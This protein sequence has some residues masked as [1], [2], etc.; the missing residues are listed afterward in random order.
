MY[1]NLLLL[2]LA[3]VAF[4]PLSAQEFSAGFRAGLNFAT[5]KGP[6]EMDDSGN[7]LEEYT[8]KSGFHVGGMA[9]LKFNDAF[10][11][12]GE[13]L[14]SQKGTESKYLGQS[15][16]IF[17][18]A[19]DIPVYATGDRNT[20]LSITNSYIDIPITAVGRLGRLEL[21]GGFN[22]GILVSSRGA[23]ELTFSGT[24][25]GGAPVDPFTIALEF[26]YF[27]DTFQRTDLNDVEIREIDGKDVLIPKTLTS[28]NQIVEGN[29]KL[30]NTLDFGLIGGLAFYL[31][32]GLFLG[33]RVNYGLSDLTKTNR[34]I[35]RK[36]LDSSK[37]FISREDDDR[38]L[39]LQASVGFSF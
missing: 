37:N 9:N 4:L 26:N 1:R 33:L 18:T 27:D 30:F 38:N 17:Y 28:Y 32:Q 11:L 7:D 16:W 31:N 2:A 20:T 39:T 13:L 23:G 14:Y 22:L 36:A 24:S 10:T 3:L 35:S 34:D 6:L 25:A 15:Y 29:D 8:L 21:S 19:D 5:I 12:R